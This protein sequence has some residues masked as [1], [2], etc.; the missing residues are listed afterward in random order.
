MQK[1][2]NINSDRENNFNII[3]FAAAIMV[4]YGHMYHII[5]SVPKT[6]LGTAVSSI[7]VKIFFLISGYLIMKSYIR[8][9]NLVRYFVRRFF[10]IIPGLIG[11]VLFSVLIV[12]PLFTSL[13]LQDYFHDSLITVYLKNIFLF[14]TYNLPGVFTENIYPNAVNGSLWS[15][16]VEVFMY[17]VLPIIFILFSKVKKLPLVITLAIF[18]ESVSIF[19]QIMFPGLRIVV[20]GSN[21]VDW[22]ALIPYFF[23]GMIYGFEEIKKHLNL[24]LGTALMLTA[25]MLDVS[26]IKGEV[27]LFFVLPYFIFSFAFADMPYFKNCFSKNDYSYGMYLYGFVVQQMLVNKLA[28]L[29]L[30]LNVFMVISTVCTLILAMISW[31]LI[32]KPC[33]LLGKKILKNPKIMQLT[34]R[35]VSG[36]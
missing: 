23:V 5:G 25:L 12:G 36:I 4:I 11:V 22:L 27:I 13:D 21:L 3:R 6:F 19:R 7:G 16:P 26:S 30:S 8:D 35:E 33:Q 29:G 17:I 20:Y 2:I 14:I 15:L 18:A 24:Q 31:H 32:E 28:Y 34:K 9:S 10:R 1:S